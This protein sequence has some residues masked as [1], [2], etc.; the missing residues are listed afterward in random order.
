MHRNEIF[1]ILFILQLQRSLGLSKWFEQIKSLN[2]ANRRSQSLEHFPFTKDS[3]LFYRE[4][5]FV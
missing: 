1:G 5:G 2:S 4:H 3:Q